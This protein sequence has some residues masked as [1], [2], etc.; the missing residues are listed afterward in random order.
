MFPF[1]NFA[2]E[3]CLDEGLCFLNPL[4]GSFYMFEVIVLAEG[5]QL[6]SCVCI[7]VCICVCVCVC[8]CLSVCLSNDAGRLIS[9]RTD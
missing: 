9:V 2:K 7:C 1:V 8:V 3:F 6:P 5:K 4:I